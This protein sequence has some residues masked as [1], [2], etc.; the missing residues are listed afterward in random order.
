MSHP[1]EN[2]PE[3]IDCFLD[4]LEQPSDTRDNRGKRHSQAFIVAA[5]VFAILMGRSKTSSI[6]RYIKNNID[7]LRNIT[8]MKD[9]KP[10]SRAHLPRLLDSPLSAKS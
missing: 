9:A 4:A 10:I 6:Y 5:T 8:G 3:H 1:L 2:N 7:W